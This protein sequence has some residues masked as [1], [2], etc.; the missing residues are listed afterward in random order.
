MHSLGIYSLEFSSP[1][2]GGSASMNGPLSEFLLGVQAEEGAL[3]F[4]PGMIHVVSLGGDFGRAGLSLVLE[5][6]PCYEAHWEC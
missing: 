2:A 3:L 1:K 5:H 4:L 6:G